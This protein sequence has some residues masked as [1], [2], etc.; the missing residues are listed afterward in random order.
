MR[1][2]SIIEYDLQN[3]AREVVMHSHSDGETWGLCVIEGEKKFFTS[4]DDNKI[5]MFDM[6]TRR[7]I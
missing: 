2:G 5:F 3:N 4:G 7:C 6:D 1:N